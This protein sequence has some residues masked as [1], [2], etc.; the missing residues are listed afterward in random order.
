LDNTI[1]ATLAS[2]GGSYALGGWVELIAVIFAFFGGI[3]ISSTFGIICLII[4]IIVGFLALICFSPKN[5]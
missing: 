1:I 5:Y 3:F 2:I 4:G